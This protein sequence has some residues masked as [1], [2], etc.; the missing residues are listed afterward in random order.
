MWIRFLEAW[1]TAR[2]LAS[3]TFHRAVQ[4]LHKMVRDARHGKDPSEMGG[5]NVDRQC[6]HDALQ[7]SRRSPT[8]SVRN[9][10]PSNSKKYLEYYLEELKEQLRGGP[11]K[12]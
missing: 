10:G 8:D 12:K 3:P 7:A 2:L 4:Q 1:L 11:R 9:L 6:S 5:T